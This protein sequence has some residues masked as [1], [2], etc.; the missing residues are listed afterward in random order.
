VVQLLRH[1]CWSFYLR[2]TSVITPVRHSLGHPFL[3]SDEIF[4]EQQSYYLSVA[5]GVEVSLLC[6]ALIVLDELHELEQNKEQ[7]G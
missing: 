5:P 3:N 6:A 2:R 1:A 7:R 4:F